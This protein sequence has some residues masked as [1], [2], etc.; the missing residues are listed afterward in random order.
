MI[1]HNKL[2]QSTEKKYVG[3]YCGRNDAY[4]YVHTHEEICEKYDGKLFLTNKDE[5][6]PAT[7]QIATATSTIHVTPA[8]HT[9]ITYDGSVVQGRENDC[10]Y[11][12]KED[13]LNSGDSKYTEYYGRGADLY[14]HFYVKPVEGM[15]LVAKAYDAMGN[16]IHNVH[17]LTTLK[18]PDVASKMIVDSSK[19]EL[20]A[21]NYSLSYLEVT[22]NDANGNYINT[23]NT[24]TFDIDVEGEGVI[25]GVDNGREA[26]T[27]KFQR[28]I[29]NQGKNAYIKDYAGKFVVIIKST[30][31]AGNVKVTIKDRNNKIATQVINLTSSL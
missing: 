28:T 18:A 8:G 2:Y 7:D 13:V 11:L 10:V 30:K 22:L 12:S 31:K 5:P 29:S 1:V 14:S 4:N 25:A 24:S 6:D 23:A 26:E 16:E 17:G 20:K 19:T 21:D 27:E 3:I 9:Y 15:K